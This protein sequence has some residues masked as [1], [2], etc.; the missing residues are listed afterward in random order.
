LEG[1]TSTDLKRMI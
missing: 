1:S